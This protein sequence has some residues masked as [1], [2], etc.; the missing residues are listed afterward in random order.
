MSALAVVAKAW[1]AEVAGSDRARSIYTK[2]LDAQGIPV[3]IGHAVENVPE[4]W[5]IVASSAI[6]SDNPEL[7][8]SFRRRG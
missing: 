4:G 1:G 7:V 8:G 5:E 2:L 6:A 3:A